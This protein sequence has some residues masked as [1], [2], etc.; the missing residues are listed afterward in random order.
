MLQA[1]NRIAVSR[2]TCRQCCPRIRRVVTTASAAPAEDFPPPSQKTIG[3]FTPAE[4][5]YYVGIGEGYL[6]Q[7][8]SEGYGP[9]PLRQWPPGIHPGRTWQTFADPSTRRRTR[10]NMCRCG[11]PARSSGHRRDEFQGRARLRRR[12]RRTFGAV[13]GVAWLPR[14][15]GRSRPSSLVVGTLRPSAGTGCRGRGDDMDGAIR[16]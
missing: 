13:P 9:E 2:S 5:A 8:G 6:R 3:H 14:S 12:H 10:R 4:A 1:T 15:G 16:Y 7:V 11:A